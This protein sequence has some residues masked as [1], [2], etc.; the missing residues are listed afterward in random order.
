MSLWF[1]FKH[2]YRVT[3]YGRCRQKV[4]GFKSIKWCLK[5]EFC[6][7][8]KRKLIVAPKTRLNEYF[9]LNFVQR[10]TEFRSGVELVNVSM[11]DG[12]LNQI[13]LVPCPYTFFSLFCIVCNVH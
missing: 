8:L 4:P 5:L 9:V 2:N 10:E 3:V 6:V 11:A 13:E 12:L 1:R 7:F